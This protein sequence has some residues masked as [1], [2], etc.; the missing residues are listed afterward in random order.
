MSNTNNEWTNKSLKVGD[1]VLI[2][3]NVCRW[4][5]GETNPECVE[6]TVTSLRSETYME[7]GLIVRWDN[8]KT[9]QYKKEDS[10]LVLAPAKDSFSTQKPEGSG[11]YSFKIPSGEFVDPTNKDSWF[12]KGEFPPAGT[13]CEVLHNLEY[14][15]VFIVGMDSEGYCVYELPDAQFEVPYS[16]NKFPNN[17]R[18]IKELDPDVV[19]LKRSFPSVPEDTL[20]DIYLACKTLLEK[21]EQKTG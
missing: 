13:T 4:V 12:E 15:E 20:K 3:W 18:P 14:V 11:N 19:E 6:G 16:G 17:F 5:K 2:D 8:G 21:Q 7:R 10:D 1:R 9:N